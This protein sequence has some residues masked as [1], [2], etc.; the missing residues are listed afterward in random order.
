MVSD[1]K[2]Y[3]RKGLKY[4]LHKHFQCYVPIKGY[5][6]YINIDHNYTAVQLLLD[7][8]LTIFPGYAWDGASGP[9]LDTPSSIR[10]SLVHDALYQLIRTQQLPPEMK[11]I[12]DNLFEK[13][14]KEDGMWGIRARVWWEAVKNFGSNKP[15]TDTDLEVKVFEAP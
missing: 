5:E 3:Y 15:Y 11:T 13:L 6:A 8:H 12:A 2:V 10:G 1:R 14:I 4:Q 7:G 9:T